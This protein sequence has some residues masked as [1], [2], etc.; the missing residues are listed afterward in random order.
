LPGSSAHQPGANR[1]QL[2]IASLGDVVPTTKRDYAG[3]SGHL[4]SGEDD[5]GNLSSKFEVW[6][7]RFPAISHSGN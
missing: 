6:W 5:K 1:V 4:A 2:T 7:P 3:D